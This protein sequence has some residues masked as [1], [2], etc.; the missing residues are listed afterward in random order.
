MDKFLSELVTLFMMLKDHVC[1][2]YREVPWWFIGAVIFAVLY[3]ISPFDLIPDFIPI[4]GQ[5][6]DVAVLLLCVRSM[7]V[8]IEKYRNWRKE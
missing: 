5:L 1:G 4:L 7:G 3:I 2:R 6:D 8:E